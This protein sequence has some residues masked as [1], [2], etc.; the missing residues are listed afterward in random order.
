MQWS[1]PLPFKSFLLHCAMKEKWRT[2][3]LWCFLIS[4]G[5]YLIKR[6]VEGGDLESVIQNIQICNHRNLVLW[7][8]KLPSR[9]WLKFIHLIWT[10]WK[11][12]KMLSKC[13]SK[14]VHL[15]MQE[16]ILLFCFFLSSQYILVSSIFYFMF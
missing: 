13:S 9:L 4:W 12:D 16:T 6:H 8:P 14:W 10:W 2:V 5:F 15:S 3:W 7:S 1:P 11:P